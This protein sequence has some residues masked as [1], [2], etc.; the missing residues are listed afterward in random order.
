MRRKRT[1]YWVFTDTEN[2]GT[3][4][5]LERARRVLRRCQRPVFL[6]KVTY[7]A[8]GARLVGSWKLAGPRRNRLKFGDQGWWKR[9]R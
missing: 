7:H 5:T 9:N 2:L 3:F 8:E 6:E 1:R 4:T